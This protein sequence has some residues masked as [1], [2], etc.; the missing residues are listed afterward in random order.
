MERRAFVGTLLVGG[1]AAA[2]T[3]GFFTLRPRPAAADAPLVESSQASTLVK[4]HKSS[5]CG[6]CKQWVQHLEQSGFRVEVFDDEDLAPIKARLGV[7]FGKG[8]C[9]TAEVEGYLVEGH[10]PAQDIRKLLAD[11]P[12]AKG[13]VL[14][15][16]P[17][18]SPG[19]EVSGTPNQPFTVELVK[20]DGE[21]EAFS[22]HNQ[23]AG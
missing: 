9:H 11:R 2:G 7:P 12:Q 5:T 6:C 14:A 3:I 21:T 15:G 19:M 17:I 16:M 23:P 4:V 10:V 20:A 22:H 18:G 1:V 13:L 8:S